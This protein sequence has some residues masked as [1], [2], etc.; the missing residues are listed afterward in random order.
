MTV[1]LA[2]AAFA[3]GRSNRP[4]QGYNSVALAEDRALLLMLRAGDATNAIQRLESYLD[5]TTYH[6]MLARPS[7]RGK[8]R[9]HLDSI[10]RKVASYRDQVPRPVDTS[11]D[12]LG[13]TQRQVDTFLHMIEDEPVPTGPVVTACFA[14]TNR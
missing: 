6:A 10:L 12:G 1:G 14:P 2:L 7:L 13:D 11:P 4:V 3:V 9:E 8:D 5:M